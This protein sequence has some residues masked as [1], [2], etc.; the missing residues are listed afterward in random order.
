MPFIPDLTDPRYLDEVG[1][2][3]YHEKYGRDKFGGS[4]D[5]ERRAYSRMLLEEVANYLAQEPTWLEDKTVVSI[6]CGCSGDLV[7]FPSRVKIA[8]DPLLYVYDQLG[9]LMPDEVGSPTLY[10]SIGA[11]ELPL[12]S[13]YADLVI[14]RN[15]L[16]HMHNPAGALKEMGR[17]LN[18]DG[19]LF[20]SVDVG[21]EPTPD[22]PTVFSIDSLEALLLQ[23]QFE[24]ISCVS[25]EVPH[26]AWRHSSMRIIARKKPHNGLTLDKEEILRG[27]RARLGE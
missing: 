17:I 20:V 6:G 22:E 8:I 23:E 21:G 2:F 4:Y 15:A 16:D 19:A 5:A 1:W 14:C 11:E 7:T 18:N 10:L 13:D 3:L 27:Y 9:L 25:D 12:L 26:S 24:I